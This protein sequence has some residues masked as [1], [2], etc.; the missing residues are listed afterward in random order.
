MRVISSVFM[1]SE[2]KPKPC[3]T[4]M[5]LSLSSLVQ[6]AFWS[7]DLDDL[8]IGFGALFQFTQ[9]CFR[10]RAKSTVPKVLSTQLH[11]QPD[12][13]GHLF[14][15]QKSR[16]PNPGKR[17]SGKFTYNSIT[18]FAGGY[19]YLAL[20]LSRIL[21]RQLVRNFFATYLISGR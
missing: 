3:L 11:T 14:E 13:L 2:Q 18:S 15:I 8:R 10:H 16:S 1:F 7:P 6:H 9:A 5:D 20:L 19:F 12:H 4:V 21:I 17:Y